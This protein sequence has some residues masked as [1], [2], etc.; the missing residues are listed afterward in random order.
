[1]QVKRLSDLESKVS[2]RLND[3][4]RADQKARAFASVTWSSSEDQDS[5]SF[6]QWQPD[7]LP[8]EESK[9]DLEI[10]DLED[11]L[12]E[13][14]VLKTG[15]SEED[16][17]SAKKQAYDDGFFKGRA[18]A[19]SIYYEAK[20]ALIDLTKDIRR[21]QEDPSI[22][23]RPLKKLALHLAEE[24]VRGE[25]NISESAIERLVKT[26]LEDI[27]TYSEEPIVVNLHPTDLEKQQLTLDAEFAHVELRADSQLSQGSVTIMMGDTAIEDLLENRLDKLAEDLFKASSNRK[28]AKAQDSVLGTVDSTSLV[29]SANEIVEHIQFVGPLLEPEGYSVTASE[30]DSENRKIIEIDSENID[31]A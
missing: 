10:D 12:S 25:L 6:K 13:E 18:E 23:F 17:Q 1:M 27:E 15:I 11:D 19:E 9:E 16:L 22:F 5:K 24:L 31:D 21:S 30:E 8:G 7:R 28:L 3:L 29:N 2:W 26:A 4:L 14:M 20:Q